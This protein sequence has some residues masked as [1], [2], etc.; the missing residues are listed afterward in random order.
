MAMN[1]SR[2]GKNLAQVIIRNSEE[3]PTEKM[4]TNI[5][6]YW[7]EIARAIISEISSNAEVTEGIV[8]NI[9]SMSA[10]GATTSKGKIL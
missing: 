7:T 5:E 2:L 3:T 10:T 4:V 6:N 9:P 1:E 8:V